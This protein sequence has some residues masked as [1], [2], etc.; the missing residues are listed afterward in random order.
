CVKLHILRL[1]KNQKQKEHNF[2]CNPH[3]INLRHRGLLPLPSILARPIRSL[4]IPPITLQP[5]TIL[6]R[7]LTKRP[8]A[9]SLT[10]MTPTL[11]AMS[12]PLHARTPLSLR[13]PINHSIRTLQRVR[14][15]RRGSRWVCVCVWR[16]TVRRERHV[17]C[18]LTSREMLW[19]RWRWRVFKLL[20]RWLT[21]LDLLL[22]CLVWIDGIVV[23]VAVG[24]AWTCDCIAWACGAADV[25]TFISRLFGV[26]LMIQY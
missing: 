17:R 19:R 1:K 24:F 3:H 12:D 7:I 22:N 16:G 9:L 20:R 6:T 23:S 5:S 21:L 2:K 15:C 25:P 4:T 13:R 18:L 10:L 11:D 26:F 14:D 8:P